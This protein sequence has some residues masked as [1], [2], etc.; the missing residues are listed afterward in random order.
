MMEPVIRIDG[1]GADPCAG[2]VRIDWPKAI[3]NGT[4]I[5]GTVAALAVATWQAVLMFLVLTYGTLLVGHS[6]GMHRMMIHRTFRAKPWVA[7]ALIYVGTLVGVSGPSGIIRIHDTRD[8]AQRKAEC[9]DFFAHRAGFWQ[10]LAWNLFSRF[11][12]VRPPRITIEPAI[13]ADPFYRFLDVTWRWQQAPLALTLYWAGGWPF[14]LWGICARV[15]VSTAG[16]WSVTYFC[17][18]PDLGTSP[19]RW[20]VKDAGIQA[21]N[22]PGLGLVTYGECWHNNHHAFPESARIGLEPGQVDPGWWVIAALERLDLVTA[23]GKPR[24][25]DAREDLLERESA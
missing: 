17:H 10:D 19:G 22:L 3:W 20:L 13:S 15:F 2:I 18:R 4:M 9:H 14:V 16:H 6:V 7:R 11:E 25:P 12:F 8:W 1:S 24:G 5:A 21:S 23:V